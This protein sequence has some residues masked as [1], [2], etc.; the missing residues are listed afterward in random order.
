MIYKLSNKRIVVKF[1]GSSIKDSFREALEFVLKLHEENEV[2]VVLSALRGVTDA[3]LG[4]AESKDKSVIGKIA[5]KHSILADESGVDC[6]ILEPL[7]VELE[8]VLK[9]ERRFPNKGAFID[10]VLSF[11]ERLSVIIFANALE[12]SGIRSEVV[13]ALH[14]IKTD[15]NFGNAAVD[16]SGTAKRIKLIEKLLNEGKVPVV[17]GFLGGYK[18]LRTTL[19]RGGSDY[20][21]TI[22]GSL[23]EARA[24]LIMSDVRGIYT[25]D[26]RIVKD[27]KLLPFV[28]YEEA[29][30][31]SALGM[32]A[33]HEKSICPVM[34]RLPV[35]LGKTDSYRLGT[36]VS[37]ISAEVPILTYK[38]VNENFAC[39][40]VVGLREVNFNAPIYKKGKNWISFLVK[41]EELENSLNDLHEVIFK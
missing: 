30:N 19:G 1:G 31:A 21:A 38:P 24:V 29:L 5:R 35:I 13:D 39:I 36:F 23:L 41:R 17:T 34:G 40:G 8:C 37:D 7:F 6:D 3:L 25:A 16:F 33:L 18:G 32:R 22:L 9:N 12:N 11:G 28:S 10:H 20:T 2:V 27:A 15:D 4:L 26:P 14:V